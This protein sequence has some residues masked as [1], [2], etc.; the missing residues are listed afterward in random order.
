[1]NDQKN[2]TPGSIGGENLVRL[3][4]SA[5]LLTLTACGGGSDWDENTQELNTQNA[6]EIGAAQSGELDANVDVAQT[7][8][9]SPVIVSVLQNDSLAADSQFALVGQPANGSATLLA[10]G[11]V[12]YTADADFEG[13]D[14]IE[15]VILDADG[16]RE[17]GKFYVAVVCADCHVPNYANVDTNGFPYCL[18][19]NPDPDGDGYGWENNQSC[20]VPQLG[21][22][23]GPLTAKADSVDIKAGET[24]TVTPLLNDTIADRANV[25]FSID[26]GPTAGKIEAVDSGVLV[27]AAPQDYSGTDS[28]VYSITDNNGDTSV[29]NINFNITCDSCVDYK[30][31]KVTW[32]ANPSSEQVEG[33]KVLFGS[34]ENPLTSTEVSNVTV[35]SG[36]T[37]TLTLDLA[38]DLNLDSNEGG[39]FMIQAYRGAEVSEASEAACFTRG[40]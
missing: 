12:E 38:A 20:V 9:G 33:Y 8:A 6:L 4:V 29:A 15:Y 18:A 11:S 7:R 22:A 30:A 13:T 1:M 16:T 26:T 40:S 17:Y 36:D 31:V 37:P 28:L 24:Q 23:L 34:D 14:I 19:S 21:A 3:A 25:K 32:A 10:D 5:A 27:Y 35:A 39:C 2:R